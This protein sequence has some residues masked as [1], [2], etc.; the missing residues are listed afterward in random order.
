MT[1]G[2]NENYEVTF[3]LDKMHEKG[4]NIRVVLIEVKE[5]V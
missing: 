1:I 4:E 5:R 3:N 2:T